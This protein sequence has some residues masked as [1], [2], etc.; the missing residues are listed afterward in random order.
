MLPEFGIDMEALMT[1]SHRE[2][3]RL[4]SSGRHP[5]TQVTLNLLPATRYYDGDQALLSTADPTFKAFS[6]EASQITRSQ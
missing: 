6:G 2:L 3:A 4:Q 1:L 5:S